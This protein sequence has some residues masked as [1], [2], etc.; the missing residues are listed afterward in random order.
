L[1]QNISIQL[2][3]ELQISTSTCLNAAINDAGHQV[4][5]E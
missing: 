5:F 4:L 1:L 2:L 3:R